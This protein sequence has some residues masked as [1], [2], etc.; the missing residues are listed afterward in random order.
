MGSLGLSMGVS[1]GSSSFGSVE[2]FEQPTKARKIRSEWV[3][4][5]PC[6]K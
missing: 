1:I 5:T 6:L 4:I 3:T 2:V